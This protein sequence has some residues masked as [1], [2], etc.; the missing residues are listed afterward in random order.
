[1]REPIR[2]DLEPSTCFV[3]IFLSWSS[4]VLS[5]PIQPS[6]NF[7]IRS[8]SI[9]CTS[10][11]SC[12]AHVYYA[13]FFGFLLQV[14]PMGPEGFYVCLSLHP[15]LEL[16]SNDYFSDKPVIPLMSHTMRSPVSFPWTTALARIIVWMLVNCLSRWA[17]AQWR[18]WYP[19][20]QLTEQNVS[21]TYESMAINE[22]CREHYTRRSEP[23]CIQFTSIWSKMIS[24]I[25]IHR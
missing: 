6:F 19:K 13:F 22:L 16:N 1:M 5:F 4:I 8:I 12:R 25:K 10:R 21:S 14:K 23:E 7:A 24:P 18:S 2:R 15:I 3:I 17:G 11:S 9:N 20:A